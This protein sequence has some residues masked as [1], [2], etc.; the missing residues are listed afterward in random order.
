MSLR[1]EDRAGRAFEI[2]ENVRKILAAW[3]KERDSEIG[4][5]NLR[6]AAER[7]NDEQRAQLIE[8]IAEISLGMLFALERE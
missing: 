6:R 8:R 1:D 3:G 4:R 2:D 5:M 7:L